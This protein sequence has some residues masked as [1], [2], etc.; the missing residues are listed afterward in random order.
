[1][2]FRHLHERGIRVMDLFR[3]FFTDNENR[4]TTDQFIRGLKKVYLP[5]TEMEMMKAA[6]GIQDH[7][8]KI[9]YQ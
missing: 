1:M 5:M 2:L 6:K 7:T 9:S 4:V 3:T 8:G